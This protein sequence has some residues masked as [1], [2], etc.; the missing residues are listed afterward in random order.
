MELT[1]LKIKMGTSPFDTASAIESD[2]HDLVFIDGDHSH[3]Q[4]TDD[5]EAILPF[6]GSK[7]IFVWHDF[8]LSGIVPCLRAAVRH[9]FRWLWLPTS[10]KMVVGVRDPGIFADLQKMFPDGVENQKSHPPLLAQTA[11]TRELI[12]RTWNAV[13]AQ[14]SSL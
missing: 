8:W 9:G 4:V 1:L 7:T 2:R 5:F 3:P 12:R 6:T 14:N 13:T 11:V 10:C